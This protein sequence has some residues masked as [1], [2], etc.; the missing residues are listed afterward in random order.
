VKDWDGAR[1]I[2][3]EAARIVESDRNL[4]YD[5]PEDNF[6]RIAAVWTVLLGHEVTAADVARMMAGLKL[7]RDAFAPARDNRVDAIGYLLCLERT[8]PTE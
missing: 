4:S 3:E 1:A 5:A 6:A 7:V 2:I 8:E